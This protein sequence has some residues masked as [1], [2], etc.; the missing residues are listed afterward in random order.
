MFV[1]LSS[2]VP[3]SP[4]FVTFCYCIYIFLY[5]LNLFHTGDISALLYI[6][7]LFHLLSFYDSATSGISLSF[8]VNLFRP[9]SL[10]LSLTVLPSFLYTLN[11][12]FCFLFARLY[13]HIFVVFIMFLQYTHFY[14]PISKTTKDSSLRQTP[15]H[16]P[17][18]KKSRMKDEF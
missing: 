8:C 3:L 15:P 10:Y 14:R 4:V 13:A 17:V 7:N 18:Y 16:I 6:F 1:S 5:G 12:F 2:S 9:V 11:L